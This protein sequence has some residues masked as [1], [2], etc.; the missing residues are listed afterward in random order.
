MH[1]ASRAAAVT[2][3]VVIAVGGASL[4]LAPAASAVSIPST[5]QYQWNVEHKANTTTNVNLRTGPGTSYTSRGLLTKGTGFT[6]YC[7]AYPHGTNWAWGKVT[8]GA[9]KGKTGWV[10]YTYLNK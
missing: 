7:L 9:N 2:S 5:C 6:H 10:A 8:S 1:I 3:A 4:A